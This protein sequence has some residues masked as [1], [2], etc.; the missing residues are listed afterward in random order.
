MTNEQYSLQ[1]VHGIDYDMFF[2]DK[3]CRN[4]LALLLYMKTEGRLK[5]DIVNILNPNHNMGKIVCDEVYTDDDD[6]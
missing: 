1:P 4:M 2:C 6:M 3:I 5:H